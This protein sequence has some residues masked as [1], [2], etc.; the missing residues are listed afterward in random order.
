MAHIFEQGCFFAA[1]HVGIILKPGSGLAGGIRQLATLP[2]EVHILLHNHILPHLTGI[3]HNACVQPVAFIPKKLLA[4]VDRVE[5]P[6]PDSKAAWA[7]I[8][9]A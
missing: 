3:S 5:V 6:Q 8:K 9:E 1:H 4:W 7:S 2:G